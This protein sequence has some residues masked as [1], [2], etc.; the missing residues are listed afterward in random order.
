MQKKVKYSY[1]IHSH[2]YIYMA[3][4]LDEHS[5]YGFLSGTFAGNL[6]LNVIND[7]LLY[8]RKLVDKSD[9]IIKDLRKMKNY[10]KFICFYY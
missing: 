4:V 8:R 9:L 5:S 1:Q 6:K 2:I 3:V 10:L 7:T